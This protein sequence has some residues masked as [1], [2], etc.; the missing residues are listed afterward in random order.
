MNGT[1]ITTHFKVKYS[2]VCLDQLLN[3]TPPPP[4]NAFQN[5]EESEKL[6]TLSDEFINGR[7]RN[8]SH[9]LL[10]FLYTVNYNTFSW[11]FNLH[12]SSSTK[13]SSVTYI[14]MAQTKH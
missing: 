8:M 4:L 1:K 13:S 14:F 2:H 6:P 9:Y 5:S 12:V 3:G 7:E 10:S 11:L